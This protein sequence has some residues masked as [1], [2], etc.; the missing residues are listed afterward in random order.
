MKSE[1]F[2][3]LLRQSNKLWFEKTYRITQNWGR[4]FTDFN[5][6]NK[7]RIKQI[8]LYKNNVNKII[9]KHNIFNNSNKNPLTNLK[10]SLKEPNDFVG[11]RG[12]WRLGSVTWLTCT[13]FFMFINYQNHYDKN[14]EIKMSD[15]FFLGNLIQ[16]KINIWLIR[17]KMT[18]I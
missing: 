14:K 5:N 7:L 2:K 16:G 4:L 13:D 9:A 18:K 10:I 3:M 6:W 15:K 1:S 17:P 12:K 11:G 8:C